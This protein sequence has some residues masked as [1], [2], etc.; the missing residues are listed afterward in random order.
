M[1]TG[2]GVDLGALS[3]EE[4]EDVLN[5][6]YDMG[7]AVP[8]KTTEGHHFRR[9]NI[10]RHVLA[11]QGADHVEAMGL[12]PL[13]HQ[14]RERVVALGL[15]EGD[16]GRRPPIAVSSGNGFVFINHVGKVTPSGFLEVPAGDVRETSLPE[17]YRHSEIFTGVRDADLLQ[18]KCGRC[19]YKRV[20]GG[21][22]ARAFNAT[23]DMYAEEPLCPYVPGTFPYGQQVEEFLAGGRRA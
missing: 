3:A 5:I 14:L 22:R 12:G 7:H 23:G 4:C 10:Q 20:C 8:V 11:Q 13:Y 9:V 15:D 17:I 16:R 19:E 1:P 2:R 18:G 21:S 6:F